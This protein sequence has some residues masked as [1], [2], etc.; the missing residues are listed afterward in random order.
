[1]N[2]IYPTCESASP[3]GPDDRAVAVTLIALIVIAALALLS[4]CTRPP[5][6]VEYRDVTPQLPAA[7]TTIEPRPAVPVCKTEQCFDDFVISLDEWGQDGW[8]HVAAIDGALY[9]PAAKK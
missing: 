6:L 8:A 1:M 4:G 2:I 9:P 5:P 3:H 7:M